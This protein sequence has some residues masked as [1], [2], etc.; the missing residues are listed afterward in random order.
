MCNLSKQGEFD[1][2][3]FKLA[4][5]TKQMFRKHRVNVTVLGGHKIHGCLLR[6]IYER[7]SKFMNFVPIAIA[8]TAIGMHL[9]FALRVQCLLLNMKYAQL[10]SN[11][12]D[13]FDLSHHTVR[14]KWRYI[15]LK[16][17]CFFLSLQMKLCF[18][19][20]VNEL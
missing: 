7:K 10:D 6:I 12:L 14:T 3:Q 5:E 16:Y 19:S 4:Q 2:L 13:V 20:C 17:Q 9:L 11:P 1:L 8:A 15:L 18:G